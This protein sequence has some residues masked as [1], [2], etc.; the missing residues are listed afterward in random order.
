MHPVVT[1]GTRG[2]K[3]AQTMSN[4]VFR[5]VN[6]D[7]NFAVLNIDEINTQISSGSF[8][9]LDIDNHL[10]FAAYLGKKLRA[11]KVVIVNIV[12]GTSEIM[13]KVEVIDVEKAA[14]TFEKKIS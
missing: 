3:F 9:Q 1:E 2:R 10:K 6:R 11:H 13:I 7:K 5:N 14:V 8:K 4:H 12:A